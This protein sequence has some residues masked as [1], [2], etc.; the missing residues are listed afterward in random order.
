MVMILRIVESLT[1]MLAHISE[2]V[3]SS[4]DIG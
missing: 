2:L 4:I 3:G 1:Q